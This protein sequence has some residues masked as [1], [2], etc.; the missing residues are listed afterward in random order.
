MTSGA[1]V[2][3]GMED[4]IKLQTDFNELSTQFN[5]L[6]AQLEKEEPT[7]QRRSPATGGDNNMKT[8]C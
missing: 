2:T 7:G 8:D 5:A 1:K 4:L 6:K 3:K